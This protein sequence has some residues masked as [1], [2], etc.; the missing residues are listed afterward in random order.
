MLTEHTYRR[1]YRASAWYDIVVT[2]PYATPIT[3]GT[4]WATIGG[5]HDTMGLDALPPL[6]VM[7]VLF[8]NFFGTVVLFW[9]V[10]RL[11]L[12]NPVLGRYDAVGRMLFSLWMVNA[13]LHGGSPIIWVFLV[14]EVC[15]GIAQ[16]LP[17]KSPVIASA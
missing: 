8:A 9:S 4:L 13:L 7:M 1:I 2:W 15:W 5:L 11:R 6:N 14:F 17:V 12:D 10:L 16:A 3:F